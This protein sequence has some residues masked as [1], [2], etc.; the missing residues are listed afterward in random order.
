MS[1]SGFVSQYLICLKKKDLLVRDLLKA[2]L[3]FASA[4]RY[5]YQLRDSNPGP[6]ARK[7]NVLTTNYTKLTALTKWSTKLTPN[8]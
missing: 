1:R 2:P 8:T 4:T 5:L 3:R 7:A 6:L